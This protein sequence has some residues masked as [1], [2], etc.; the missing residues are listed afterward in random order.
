MYDIHKQ[1][2]W[3]ASLL[4][5]YCEHDCWEPGGLLLILGSIFLPH[6]IGFVLCFTNAESFFCCTVQSPSHVAPVHTAE[7][8]VESLTF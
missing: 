2:V 7:D 8:A 4:P 6:V 3:T 1:Y 5:H